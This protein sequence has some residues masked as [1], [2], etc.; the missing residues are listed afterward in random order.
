MFEKLGATYIKLGQ[1][2][3]SS[4]TLFPAE[5][6]EEFSKCLDKT[7]AVPWEDIE[8]VLLEDLGRPIDVVFES[9]DKEPLATASIA[10]VHTAVLKGSRREVVVKVRKP[11]VKETLL[12]DLS[13]IY[14]AARTLEWLNP[15]LARTSFADIAGDIR[16][17]MMEEVDFT[18]E[19]RHLEE[20]TSFLD[21]LDIQ[22][23]TAPQVFRGAS[24]RRVLTMERLR[25]VPLTDLDAIK[26][27]G[28]RNPENTLIAALNTWFASVLA[29]STF[30]A[31]VHAGN[32]LVLEDGRVG[33]IDFGIVGSISAGTWG[34]IETL[35]LSLNTREY[36]KMAMALEQIGATQ[37]KVDID[38]FAGD[39]RK[40]FEELDQMETELVDAAS[41]DGS[42]VSAGMAVNEAQ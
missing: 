34:A 9:I 28:V 1:F 31:D 36:V 16:T 25:G 13:F 41:A 8:K 6:V 5:Y 4:P 23:A 11:G 17:S 7:P 35:L 39:L 21:R 26:S 20:F 38:K 3:A 30:H 42:Q 10:Q 32:L 29:C 33:V 27:Q 40:V 12:A 37:E 19:A 22:E 2:I 15:E 18:K 14:L 24:S